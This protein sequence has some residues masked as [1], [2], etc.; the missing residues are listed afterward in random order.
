LVQGG[1]VKT[2]HIGELT[3]DA[4]EKELAPLLSR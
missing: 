4:I 2:I 3:P 1:T